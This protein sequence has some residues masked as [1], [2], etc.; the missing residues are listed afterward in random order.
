MSVPYKLHT[1]RERF[2]VNLRMWR[3]KRGFSQEALASDS[4]LSR[5]FLSRIETGTATISLDNAEKLAQVLRIDIVD[6][7]RP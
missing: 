1:V 4:G 5:V 3:L 6:L 2:A 7:L